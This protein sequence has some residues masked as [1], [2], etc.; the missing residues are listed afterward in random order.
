MNSAV[1]WTVGLVVAWVAT[2][3]LGAITIRLIEIAVARG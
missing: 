3:L 1:E 2:R